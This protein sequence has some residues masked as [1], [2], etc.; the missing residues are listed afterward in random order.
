MIYYFDNIR[1]LVCVPY[2]DFSCTGNQLTS[3]EGCPKSIGGSFNCIRNPVY[4]IWT[5]FN[6]YDIV[7]DDS[8]VLDRLNDFLVTIGKEPVESVEGYNNYSI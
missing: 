4:N 6:D 2:N 1:H 8:I 7:R 5:L 3:L